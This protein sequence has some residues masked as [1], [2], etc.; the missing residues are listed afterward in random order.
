MPATHPKME[1][2]QISKNN[3]DK[4]LHYEA[5]IGGVFTSK[6]TQNTICDAEQIEPTTIPRHMVK[7]VNGY[8]VSKNLQHGS[9]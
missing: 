5:E 7:Q 8:M 3:F 2:G 4:V 1:T 6:L 9:Q